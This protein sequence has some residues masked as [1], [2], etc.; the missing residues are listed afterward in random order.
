MINVGMIV[1]GFCAVILFE[2]FS[3]SVMSD[4]QK[5]AVFQYSHLQI[6]ADASWDMKPVDEAEELLMPASEELKEKIRQA[7]QPKTI[8]GRLGFYSLISTGENSVAAKAV[9]F[10]P[11][12]ETEMMMLMK[13]PQGRPLKKNDAYEVLVGEGLNKKLQSKVGDRLTLLAQTVHGSVNALDV[14]MVGIA[15]TNMTE[16]DDVTFYVPLQTAQKLLDTDRIER[17]AIELDRTDRTSASLKLVN[18]LL[19]EGFRAKPWRD[20]ARLYLQTESY[21][22]VQNGVIETIIVALVL[23]SI[24]NTVGNSVMERTGEIGTVRALGDTRYDVLRMFLY[25]G[26]ILAVVAGFL[27]CIVGVMLAHFVTSMGFTMAT[28]G[29]NY[30]LPIRIAVISKAFVLAFGLTSGATLFATV[31]PAFRA[32][33]LSIVESLKRNI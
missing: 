27:A 19:P 20:L 22:K 21:F 8:A 3:A 33:R 17:M 24:V 5:L 28:P 25:E 6:G 13:F 12:R 9:S 26:L 32:S 30:D 1:S 14:E 7:I 31:I 18:S 29:A 4:L 15:M 11:E 16:I 23:L 2:G 10:D